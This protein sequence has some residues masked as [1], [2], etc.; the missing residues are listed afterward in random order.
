MAIPSGGLG[1]PLHLGGGG[2]GHPAAVAAAAA[3]AALA[4]GI[5]TTAA[6]QVTLQIRKVEINDAP[7]TARN[8]LT[9][10][11]MQKDMGVKT[12]ASVCTKGRYYTPDELAKRGPDDDPPLYLELSAA[13]ASQLDAGVQMI[14]EIL[15]DTPLP[16][17]RPLSKQQVDGWHVK[18]V[19]VNID[20]PAP[21]FSVIGK[22]L[23]PKGAYVKHVTNTSGARLDLKGRGSRQQTGE[24]S[25]DE[26]M[27]FEIS[28]R[29]ERSVEQAFKLCTDLVETVRA[30][31]DK[32]GGRNRQPPPPTTASA[33]AAAG[34]AA[35]GPTP[36]AANPSATPQSHSAAPPAAAV[37]PHAAGYP[38]PGTSPVPAHPHAHMPPPQHYP[39]PHRPA[40]PALPPG[41]ESGSTPDG[42][43][44]YINHQDRTTHWSLPAGQD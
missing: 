20:D 7:T 40:G 35:A 8:I 10:G 19:Y 26:P 11:S 17:P 6:A 32:Y 12:G 31:H 25:A 30:E 28:S 15:N 44:Y 4:A 18:R 36:I 29:T 24:P 5:S 27:F 42:R 14:N 43:T 23:G 33:A 1:L 37:P 41:W 38:P 9:R 13:E 16:D 2:L 3:A 21:G 22:L 39:M 34:P